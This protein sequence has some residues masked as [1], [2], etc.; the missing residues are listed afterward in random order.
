LIEDTKKKMS[1]NAVSWEEVDENSK[2]SLHGRK[3][4]LRG[5]FDHVKEILLGPRPPPVGVF[6]PAA[7]GMATNPSGYYVITPFQA[8]DGR[9]VLVNR[10]WVGRQTKTWSHPADSKDIELLVIMS[11]ME[12]RGKFSPVNDHVS[13]KLLWLEYEAVMK[14]MGYDKCDADE[15]PS[16]VLEAVVDDVTNKDMAQLTNF[17]VPK[18]LSK[19]HE[20]YVGPPTHIA[21][22][23]TWFSLSIAAIVFGYR[24]NRKGRPIKSTPRAS[25]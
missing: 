6:G 12:K 10:G 18:M 13:K 17:P 2:Q 4:V 9:L 1:E 20:Q 15:R 14:A 19:A 7:Q 22:A 16:Y 21:Y 11:D 24:M 5:K 8:E 25:V 23:T 3:I